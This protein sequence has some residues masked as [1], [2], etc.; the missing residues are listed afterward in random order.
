MPDRRRQILENLS[1][2]LDRMARWSET[3]PSLPKVAKRA[4]KVSDQFAAAIE[5]IDS[6]LGYHEQP[7]GDD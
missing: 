5:W 4:R 2:L 3:Q 7:D 1:E 6:E